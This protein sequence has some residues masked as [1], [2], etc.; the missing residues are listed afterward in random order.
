MVVI[1]DNYDSFTYNIT[2]VLQRLYAGET[3]VLRSKECTIADIEALKPDYLIVGPG[4][5][6]PRD[7]GISVDA[8]RH[9]AH[10]VPILGVCLGHQAIGVAFGGKIEHAKTVRHGKVEKMELDGKGVFRTLGKEGTFVRYHS[11]VID[12]ASLPADLEVTATSE[13]GDIMGVRYKGEG[14]CV[15]GIQF[16]PESIASSGCDKL[17]KA[18]LNYRKEPFDVPGVLNTLISKKDLTEEQSYAFMM[19]LTDGNIDPCVTSAILVG[20]ESKGV[21]ASEL[22]GAAK[23]LCQKKTPLPLSSEGVAEIVGTG[24][25]GKGSFNISSLSAIVAASCGAKVAKHGNKAVTSKSGASDF[26]TALGLKVDTTPERTAAIIEKTNF[27]FLLAPIYHKAM[28]QAAPI[29]NALKIKTMM[30]ILGPLSNPA[31]AQFE[32]LG[33]YTPALLVSVAK[34]AKALGAKRVMAVSSLDGYDEISPCALT[35]VVQINEDDKVYEYT[36]DPAKF[37]I[38]GIDEG[39]LKGGTAAENAV[40]ANEILNGIGRKGLLEAVSLNAGALLYLTGKAK[41]LLEGHNTARKAIL[42]GTA[43]KKL[44][45]IIKVSNE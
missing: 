1:I 14:T 28:A 8:I 16:H 25:D 3:Q 26:Y 36:I 38:A 10:K 6:T 29:R 44:E 22:S 37:G 24:G 13:D 31:G 23:V 45:E 19:D 21:A 9:F 11:L 40:L 18:F 35:K 17:F 20:I 5:G 7:A 39:E 34:A 4:P 43:L 2:Q 27:G 42:D 33:V 32:V 12:E 30:N 41:T 15:E